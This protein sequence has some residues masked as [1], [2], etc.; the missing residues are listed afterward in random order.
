MLSPNRDEGYPFLETALF[1]S[2]LIVKLSVI[3]SPVINL[4]YVTS[5][6]SQ[7]KFTFNSVSLMQ[8]T[9]LEYV[10]N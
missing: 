8:S 2:I 9:R 6:A 1:R 4:H 3:T 7:P 10:A 5:K